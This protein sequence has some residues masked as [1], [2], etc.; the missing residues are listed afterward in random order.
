MLGSDSGQREAAG[1]IAPAP[2][3]WHAGEREYPYYD[4]NIESVVYGH[5]GPWLVSVSPQMF[6]DRILLTRRE[7]YPRQWTAGFCYDKGPA[8]GLA[9][10]LWNPLVEF[11]PVGFKRIA[12]DSRDPNAHD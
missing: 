5:H 9:A 11:Y 12:A 4:E 7:Q 3:G 8:A 10:A 1:A 2:A 6:N